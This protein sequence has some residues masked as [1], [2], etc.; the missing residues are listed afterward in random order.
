MTIP[1]AMPRWDLE[2]FFPGLDSSDFRD[3]VQ[4]IKTALVELETLFVTAGI[5]GSKPSGGDSV[6][7]FDEVVGKWN[8]LSTKL[9]FVNAFITGQVTTD[10]RNEAA[11]ASASEM[12]PVL[13]RAR[14]LGKSL[15]AWLGRQNIDDLVGKSEIAKA[16]RFTLEK[17]KTDARHLMSSVE[18]SLVSELEMTSVIAWGKLHGNI[19]SQLEVDFEGEKVP[20]SVIRSLAYD[21]SRERRRA[22][23]EAELAAWQTV[24]IPL[25]A[26]MNSIKGEAGLLSRK[27]GWNSPIDEACDACNMDRGTLDAMM[28]AAHDS[29]PMFRRYFR[30]KARALGAERLP[31]FD[32]FAPVGEETRQ[33]V[34]D[35]A[36]G[37]VTESF[38][39]YSPKLA[40]FAARTF[41]ERWTD[42][43]PRPGKRDGAYCMSVRGDE[44]RI[45]MNF[46][47]S[48]GS[49]STLAHELGHAYH[50]VCLSTRT[51]MQRATPM[52]LAETASIFC[53]TII[54][55][56]VLKNGAP[57]DQ[58]AVLEASLQGS[59]Q[60]VVDITSRFLFEKGVFEKRA[61]RELSARELCDL[62]EQSQ[63]DTYGE[64]LD[65]AF[66]HSYMWA[67]KPH[68]YGR[69]FYNFPYMFGLLFGLGL[70]E[71][72]EKDPES[73]KGR[74]DELLSST[75]MADAATLAD[76]FGID[77]RTPGFWAGSLRQVERDVDRFESLI[78]PS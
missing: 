18:E 53:E 32:L 16:H 56:A 9:R 70:Y 34:F 66:L 19:T 33:W 20:M 15:T 73:F 6:Q 52:T 5:E 67:V 29:F 27:R 41:R 30:A 44:S 2:V 37:F 25:S 4:E 3:A 57:A 12:D 17:A 31:W 23:Y 26:A 54:R 10:S 55:Q 77:I 61:Q 7:D 14:R 75:G 45:L 21:P 69:S 58:L 74:Y 50:N 36:A 24:Q 62:M 59:S 13:A 40:D 35:E 48:F 64:G 1:A 72:Y 46:K 68:Y 63:L 38:G 71:I 28:S 60:V 51:P 39:E 11:L 22:A 43:E 49:V 8:E 76:G 42:A 65:P 47:P 78:N